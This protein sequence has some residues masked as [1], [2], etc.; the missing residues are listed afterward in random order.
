MMRKLKNEIKIAGSNLFLISVAFAIAL[1]FLAVTAGNLLHLSSIGFEV[2]FPFFAA[3]AIGEWGKTKADDN[4][5]VI[6]SQSK[7]L[8]KWVVS[9][10]FAIWGT[11]SLMAAVAIVA[12]F[13]IRGEMPLGELL[14]T[15]LPTSFFLSS[16]SAYIGLFYSQEHIAT[17]VCGIIWLVML[18]IRSLLRIPGVEYFYLFIRFAGD[19]NGV[20][21]VNKAI[22]SLVG[23]AIWCAI[24]IICKERL[25]S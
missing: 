18:L 17:L 19:I 20:W 23:L 1:I 5:D 10:Y 9:R 12:V 13:I 8:F 7:S 21:L 22:L 4:Y 3:I 11:V 2:I 25:N 6:A 24:Y 16:L 15:Y 14:L